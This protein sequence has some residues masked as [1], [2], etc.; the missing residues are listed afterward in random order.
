MSEAGDAARVRTSEIRCAEMTSETRSAAMTLLGA[1][2]GEDDHYLASSAAYGD[3]GPG[4]LGHALDLFLLHRE[5]GFVWL[6][7]AGGDRTAVGAC[8]VCHAISTSKGTLV[9]KLDDVTIDAKWQGRGVG[10]A[11]LDA[12]VAR[13]RA[14]GITRIDTACHRDNVGA[15]VSTSGTASCRSTRSGSRG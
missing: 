6:A 12:L 5:I 2:L 7:F 13:L 3:G 9:A 11:M 14:A 15:C 4:A 10:S 1:F 8:V